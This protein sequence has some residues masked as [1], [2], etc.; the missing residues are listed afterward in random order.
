MMGIN[1]QRLAA[2]MTG[3]PEGP[4]GFDDPRKLGERTTEF[5]RIWR[6]AVFDPEL[7]H[8]FWEQLSELYEQSDSLAAMEFDAR[9]GH[10]D[11]TIDMWAP[12]VGDGVLG[13]HVVAYSDGVEAGAEHAEHLYHQLPSGGRPRWIIV[14]DFID[15]KIVDKWGKR[16]TQRLNLE[17]LR[18]VNNRLGFLFHSTTSGL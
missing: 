18:N 16:P 14:F 2:I 8:L 15:F 9:V 12:G 1:G 6:N 13:Q 5:V 11:G 3:E 7:H 4:S 17:D 10:V